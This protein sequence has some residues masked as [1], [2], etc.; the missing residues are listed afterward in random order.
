MSAVSSANWLHVVWSLIHAL[1]K[2][3]VY[4]RKSRGPRNEPWGTPAGTPS[5]GET[6]GDHSFLNYGNNRKE[7]YGAVVSWRGFSAFLV[8]WCDGCIPPFLMGL[9]SL[10]REVEKR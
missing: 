9:P 5:H 4:V 3:M 10:K 1:G 6:R 7:G 8:Y 2:S